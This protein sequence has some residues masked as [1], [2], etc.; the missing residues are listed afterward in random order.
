[1]PLIYGI[2]EVMR[3]RDMRLPGDFLI[4]ADIAGLPQGKEPLGTP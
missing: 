4:D 2:A 3:M 1:M